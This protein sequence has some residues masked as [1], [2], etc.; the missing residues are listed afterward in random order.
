VEEQVNADARWT[1]KVTVS[2]GVATWPENGKTGPALLVAADQAMYAAKH[3][4][5][6]QVVLSKVAA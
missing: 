2:I 4:G 1:Q 6:N 3:Q 5:R